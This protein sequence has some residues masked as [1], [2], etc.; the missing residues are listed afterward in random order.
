MKRSLP[1]LIKALL[2]TLLL[3]NS[4]EICVAQLNNYATIP[5]Y[6]GFESG[7]LDSNWYITSSMPTGRIQVWS[8]DTLIWVGDTAIAAAGDNFLGMDMPQGGTFNLNQ[9][10]LG[11][12]LTGAAN[13]YFSFW[14]SDWNDETSPD[15]GIYISQD[16]GLTF[17]KVLDLLG[18]NNPDLNWVYF[19]L[20]LDSINIAHNLTYGPNYVIKFQQY[21]D[22]YMGGGN[23]GFLFDEINIG[24]VV[25]SSKELNTNAFQ[26][27]PNPTNDVLNI[28]NSVS[29]QPFT[30]NITNTLGQIV[31]SQTYPPL[32]T[33]KLNLEMEAGIY[34]VE[35]L[36]GSHREVKQLIKK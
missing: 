10:W 21:D 36:N 18:A 28:A 26:M 31:M 20:N 33:I 11:L 6:Q 19:N 34:F 2:L 5:Y 9:A 23:D 30:V 32:R 35:V 29:D 24:A 16:A 3:S 22:Y 27:F 14:W 7:V 12:N 8:S 4:I 17:V 15:D 1:K 25:T 13:L